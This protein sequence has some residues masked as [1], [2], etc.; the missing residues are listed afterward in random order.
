MYPFIHNGLILYLFF[1]TASQQHLSVNI[2]HF[3][4]GATDR[5]TIH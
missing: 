5:D 2:A 3:G 1:F 4:I